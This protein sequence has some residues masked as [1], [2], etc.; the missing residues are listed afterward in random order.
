V[1]ALGRI[2]PQPT[3][4]SVDPRSTS[5]HWPGTLTSGA[6]GPTMQSHPNS[7][8]RAWL[9]EVWGPSVITSN[10]PSTE[11][12]G[13]VASFFHLFRW[14]RFWLVHRPPRPGH[15]T[16]PRLLF[17]FAL[18]HPRITPTPPRI[19]CLSTSGSCATPPPVRSPSID[20]HPLVNLVGT[21]CTWFG[22]PGRLVRVLDGG[23][24]P[25]RVGVLHHLNFPSKHWFYRRATVRR[26]WDPL[27][28]FRYCLITT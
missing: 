4:L 28:S 19:L 3:C 27:P 25:G 5:A 21:I 23:A 10:C 7:F 17:S 9:T 1:P 16:Q 8:L 22:S 24:L 26:G 12:A 20:S 13:S 11:D 14:C 6:R 15:K 2:R 18:R